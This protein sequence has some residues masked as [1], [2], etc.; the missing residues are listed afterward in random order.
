MN[1]TNSKIDNMFSLSKRNSVGDGAGQSVAKL[2]IRPG[3]MLVQKRDSSQNSVSIPTIKVRVKYGSSFH[4]I[5]ISSQASF[6][7]LKKM[8][9]EPT[10]LHPQDQKLIFKNKERS[11]K[12]YLDA[13]RVRDGSKIVLVEDIVSRERRCLEMLKNVKVEMA[14]KS[15]AEISLEVDK[16]AGQLT[17]LETTASRGGQVSK[18]DVENLTEIFM[19]KLVKLDGIVAEGDLKMPRMVQVRRVQKHIETLD[20]LK[21]QNSK[22]RNNGGKSPCQPQ[23]DSS[24]QQSM[25]M[26]IQQVQLR[27]REPTGKM[28][29]LLQK[30]EWHSESIVATTQW[31]T[32]D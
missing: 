25:P 19:E 6:G 31:E 26:Q 20:A 14:S 16:L 9:A 29:M 4:D 22:P 11:S 8:L 13:E 32:F 28:P 24:R 2:E 3:G 23:A 10:G 18:M 15:L 30:P 12:A 17:A 21:L 7:E 5:R 1:P 27:Q